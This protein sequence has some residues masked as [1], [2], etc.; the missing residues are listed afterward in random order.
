V[1]GDGYDDAN[2]PD[3]VSGVGWLHVG[4]AGAL[5][6][7]GSTFEDP[8]LALERRGYVYHAGIGDLNGD[9]FADSI[10]AVPGCDDPL[11]HVYLGAPAGLPTRPSQ[12]IG[13]PAHDCPTVGGPHRPYPAAAALSGSTH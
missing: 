2:F 8:S 5:G 11:A 3:A 7:D 6:R 13:W 10:A 9:G 4:S 1:N 12:V